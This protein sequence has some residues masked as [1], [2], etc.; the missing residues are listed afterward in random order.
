MKR[1]VSVPESSDIKAEGNDIAVF[2]DIFFSFQAQSTGWFDLCSGAAVGDE[3]IIGHDFGFDKASFEIVVNSAG[4]FGGFGLKRDN[5]GLDF[6]FA[7]GSLESGRWNIS[8]SVS[9][10]LKAV[11]GVVQA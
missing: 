10:N 3:I 5:P 6:V 2:N 8:F 1:S 9:S 11:A 7:Q 4:S